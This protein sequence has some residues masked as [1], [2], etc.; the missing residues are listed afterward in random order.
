MKMDSKKEHRKLKHKG[1]SQGKGVPKRRIRGESL[2]DQA[3]KEEIKHQESR[4][5]C[6]FD[7]KGS[8]KRSSESAKLGGR[9]ECL[10][11]AMKKMKGVKKKIDNTLILQYHGGGGE[12]SLLDRGVNRK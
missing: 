5:V 8:K 7:P 10:I 11:N 4:N 9:Y 1:T 3:G 2:F 12:G 6:E